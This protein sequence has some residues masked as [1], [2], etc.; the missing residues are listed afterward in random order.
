MKRSAGVTASA[1]ISTIGGCCS[2]LLGGLMVFS[3]FGGP[4]KR[5]S[6]QPVPPLSPV[7][8]GIVA[9][10][11]FG[12]GVWGIVSA[13]GLLRL[14]NWARISFA[15]YGV[16]LA[17]FCALSTASGV[18]LMALAISRNIQPNDV[19][20]GLYAVEFALFAAIAFLF[21]ALGV[22]WAIY[23]SRKSVKIQFL[24]EALASVPRAMP[25]GLTVVGWLFVVGAAVA[26][27]MTF[28]SLPLFLFGF[29]LHG[30]LARLGHLAWSIA[31][32]IAGVGLLKKRAKAYPVA[33][34]CSVFG[35]MNWAAIFVT[36]GA[37]NQLLETIQE[38]S[39]H[40]AT[41]L[42]L[43]TVA[44]WGHLLIGMIMNLVPLLLLLANRKAFLAA[45]RM[46]LKDSAC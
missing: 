9:I 24:G 41:A 45:S 4:L 3:P 32:L 10:F 1:V 35:L 13:I 11:F 6:N 37:M 23:F 27:I 21:A 30:W 36:P 8:L 46:E 16:L 19:P 28:F 34:G 7:E 22:F 20:P 25:I 38:A 33:V 42:H 43:R 39:G 31:A 44:L 15:S 2:I 14:R 40:S 17:F 29:S 5:P 18:S 26:A 12:F